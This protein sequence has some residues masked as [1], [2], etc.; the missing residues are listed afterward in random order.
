MVEA[1]YQELYRFAYS[2]TK[3]QHEASDLTQQTFLIYSTKGHT[4]K[5][6]AKIKSW[7]FTTLYREFLGQ[8]RKMS[9]LEGFDALNIEIEDLNNKNQNI[10]HKEEKT[11]ILNALDVIDPIYKE[12]IVLFYLKDLS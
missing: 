6:S 12:V 1:Y 7:L 2:L 10:I 9:R 8:R 5:N 11:N 4:I 3:N